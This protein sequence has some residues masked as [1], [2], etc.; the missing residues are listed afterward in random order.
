[1]VEGGKGHLSKDGEPQKGAK[2]ARVTQIVAE[3]KGGLQVEVLD[4]NPA[5]VL[6]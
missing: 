4:W 2:Q 5:K 6:D 1:M 3:K